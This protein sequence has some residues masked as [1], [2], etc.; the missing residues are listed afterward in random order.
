ADA[1]IIPEELIVL[2]PGEHHDWREAI[3]LPATKSRVDQ[4]LEEISENL[5]KAFEAGKKFGFIIQAEGLDHC[6]ATLID[7]TAER[8]ERL[9]AEY[10]RRHIDERFTDWFGSKV[11][12]VRVQKLGYA[13]RGVL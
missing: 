2:L 7:K 12:P 10:T 11:H 13:V 1:V 3:D 5:K 8:L 6:T 4:R 9:D